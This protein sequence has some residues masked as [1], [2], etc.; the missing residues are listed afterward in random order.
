[1]RVGERR[2]ACECVLPAFAAR[3]VLIKHEGNART[4]LDASAQK[5]LLNDGKRAAHEGH[6]T[7][8]AKLPELQDME[9]SLDNHQRLSAVKTPAR[10]GGG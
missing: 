3:F 4:G 2:K 9:S 1:M 7:F 10:H 5:L 6:N 8:P